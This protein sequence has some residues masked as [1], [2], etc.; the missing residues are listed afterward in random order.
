MPAWSFGEVWL[1][2]SVLQH[3][4]F[5]NWIIFG[6]VRVAWSEVLRKSAQAALLLLPVRRRLVFTRPKTPH[7]LTGCVGAARKID[8]TPPQRLSADRN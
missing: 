3:A 7:G 8:L 2:A 6:F 1:H 4:S 5:A